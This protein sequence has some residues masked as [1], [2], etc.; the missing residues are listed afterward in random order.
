MRAV[1]GATCML[2]ASTVHADS[3]HG[4]NAAAAGA[5]AAAAAPAA[6]A[7]APAV[8]AVPSTPEPTSSPKGL[9]IG[10][11]LGDP[12]SATV[13]YFATKVVA[14]AALGSATLESPGWSFHA[15]VQGV[16]TRLAPHAVLRVGLGARIYHHSHLLS[17]D[18][19]PSTHFGARASV[20]LA[21]QT[22]SM[23]LYAELA[24]GVDLKRTNS[25]TLADGPFSVCPHA[26][27]SP[28]F[29][30]LAVGARFFLSH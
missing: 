15:D 10:A 8:V 1:A 11:E 14:S 16:A 5:A 17:P 20:A 12:T 9:A 26:Q 25:C 18:E 22:G 4:T 27:E 13:A 7:P 21:Y 23:E 29:L 24:P 2:L 3:T 19:V 28:L 30:Q 6:A